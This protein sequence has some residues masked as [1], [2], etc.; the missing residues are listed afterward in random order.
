MSPTVSSNRIS[1]PP[2]KNV[3]KLI[4][5]DTLRQ[6][7]LGFF[8]ITFAIRAQELGFN[9]FGLG[10]VTTISVLV[11]IAVTRL[12]GERVAGTKS[13]RTFLLLSGLLMA[14]TGLLVG[15]T[16]TTVAF[17]AAA[18]LGFLPP[19]GGQFVAA[20][21]EGQLAHTEE[22]KRTE[23]FANYGL[24]T[25][26]AGAI[27][28][29]AAALPHLLGASNSAAITDMNLAYAII[30]VVVSLVAITSSGIEEET[31]LATHKS[32]D[33]A[34]SSESNRLINR[35]S[36]LFIV[37]ST[38]SGTVTPALVAF[39]LHQRYQMTLSHLALLYFV[40]AILNSLSFPL[41][42]K[43]AKRIGLLNTAVFTHIPSS[44]LLIAVPFAGNASI[45]SLLLVARSI[46]VEMDIPTRQSYI[47]SI[48]EPSLR[49]RAAARTSMGK[50]AGR[51]IGPL[52]GG[53]TLSGIGAVAPFLIG[54]VLK[55]GYDVSLW[56]SFRRVKSVSSEAS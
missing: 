38:G 23:T 42:A 26:T 52:L 41:A 29:L 45:A 12:V 7:G 54:G 50:Q 18:L 20:L 36:L 31:P 19:L 44:L 15:L 35:L 27:G 28:A 6:F 5:V 14:T 22:S 24:A 37:D 53:A 55:I 30:G 8:T 33:P 34:V 10:I 4:A 25:T 21:V 16:T 56:R 9:A 13:I 43:I 39:W 40:M 3:T 1:V 46:L 17:I 11:S 2:L 32:D 47:A 48:V 51:A 49:R